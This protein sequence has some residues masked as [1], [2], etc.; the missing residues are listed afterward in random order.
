[1]APDLEKEET[2]RTR[3]C[4]SGHL[5]RPVGVS[6]EKQGTGNTE[7]RN[8]GETITFSL[9]QTGWLNEVNDGDT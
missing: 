2:S 4:V 6:R 9:N 8:S 1:M 5:P 7:T 3:L